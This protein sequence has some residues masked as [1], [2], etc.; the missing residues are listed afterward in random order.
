MSNNKDS[1]RWQTSETAN[2]DSYIQTMIDY[3]ERSDRDA[4]NKLN[5]M[6]QKL[7]DIE[8]Q[9]ETVEKQVTKASYN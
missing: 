5:S 7:K 2:Q 9:L 6:N 4:K 8:R 1:Y 3:A